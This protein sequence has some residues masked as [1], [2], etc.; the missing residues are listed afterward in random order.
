MPERLDA[1]HWRDRA[2]EARSLAEQMTDPES[3]ERMLRIAA[4]YDKLAERAAERAK[5]T[6]PC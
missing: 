5:K 3:R 2:E 6:A 4:D 1:A